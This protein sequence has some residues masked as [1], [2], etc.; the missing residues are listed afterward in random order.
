MLGQLFVHFAPGPE[1]RTD[2]RTGVV[3]NK[4]GNEHWQLEFR[5]GNYKFANV[6]SAAQLTGFVFFSTEAEQRAF[7][8]ELTA[9]KA[10]SQDIN[11]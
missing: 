8:D 1:G 2:I 4:V 5:T 6:F 9:Q 3:K 11:Q 10:P 7:L